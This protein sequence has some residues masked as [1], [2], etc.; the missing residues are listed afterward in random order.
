MMLCVHYSC[1]SR[2][3]CK[4][5]N[6]LVEISG[7]HGCEYENVFW[8]VAPC[9][10]VETDRRFSGAYCLHHQGNRPAIAVSTSE[11]PVNF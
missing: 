4:F 8:D 5:I 2:N 3:P 6:K 10:L 1:A 7:S 11:T 9:S